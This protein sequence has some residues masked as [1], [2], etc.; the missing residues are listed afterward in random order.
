MEESGA[1]MIEE[2]G[3]NLAEYLAAIGIG[4][5][6]VFVVSILV[7]RCWYKND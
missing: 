2:H 5:V 1:E 4:G 3:T 7:A 6:I